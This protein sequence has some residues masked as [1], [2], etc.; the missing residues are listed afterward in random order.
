M[1]HNGNFGLFFELIKQAALSGA[2]IA[3]FQLGWRFKPGEINNITEKELDLIFKC[4]EYHSIEPM[5]SVMT[6]DALDMLVNRNL[7]YFKIASRTVK[8][9]PNLVNQVLK[10]DKTTFISL[11]M[12]DL[13]ERP[14]GKSEKIKYLWCKSNYPT[15]P[16]DIKNFPKDFTSNEFFGYSDHCVG[17][18]MALLSISRGAQLVEKH[19]TLDKSDT[20]IRDHALSADPKEFRNMVEI[21]RLMFNNLNLGI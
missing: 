2:D 4:C 5:F 9:N 12:N 16:W 10:L 7:R 20:T 19:F 17:I 14:F 8:D 18:D 6:K 1:N 11:G 3:K 13:N 15:Y 21:G